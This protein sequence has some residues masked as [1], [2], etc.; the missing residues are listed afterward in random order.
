MARI[1]NHKID[2]KISNLESFENYNATIHAVRSGERY[3]IVHWNTVI[4]DYNIESSKI[5]TLA[6]GY[7]SQTT[8]TLVGRIVRALP[9]SVV[10][11]LL[12]NPEMPTYDKRRILRMLRI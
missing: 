8:S 2:E 4:L 5:A 9:R 11:D 6:T 10:F 7:I 3:S 12:S 1:A